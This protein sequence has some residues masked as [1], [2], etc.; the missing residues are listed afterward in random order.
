[1]VQGWG[2]LRGVMLKPSQKCDPLIINIPLILA[3][4]THSDL[5]V[6]MVP[7]CKICMKSRTSGGASSIVGLVVRIFRIRHE[8]STGAWS[9]GQS[10]CTCRKAPSSSKQTVDVITKFRNVRQSCVPFGQGNS[11]WSNMF[12]TFSITFVQWLPT[13]FLC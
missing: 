6:S 2:Q 10:I 8:K 3:V 11:W 1:M 9:F 7:S 5:D 12:T 4:F 13:L